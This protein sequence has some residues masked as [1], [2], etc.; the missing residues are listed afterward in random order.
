M[1]RLQGVN[2]IYN[3]DG[4]VFKALDDVDL[5]IRDGEFTAIQGPSGSGKSTLMH[6]IGLL[7][8]PSS[9]K[10]LINDRDVSRF[11]DD[12]LSRVR[13]EVVGFVFQQF[14]LINKLTI[15]ENVVLPTIY[16]HRKLDFDPKIRAMDLL[17]RFGIGDR[18]KSFPNKI[19]GGQQQRVAIARAL[20]MKPQL[21]LADEPTGNLDSKTGE[22]ILELLS[23]LNKEDK[24]TVVVVTHDEGVARRTKRHIKIR[25]GKIV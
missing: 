7:D 24:V 25:D 17:S 12:Q 23:A 22:K 15:L 11:S 19:S 21:V 9:G 1:I 2:K 13:N 4:E 14:N 5:E 16:A 18:A 8:Q 6:V 3:L 10:I 20:I